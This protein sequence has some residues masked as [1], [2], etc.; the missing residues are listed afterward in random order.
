MKQ[1]LY[2]YAFVLLLL[3]AVVSVLSYGY[4]QGY[5]YIYFRHWQIQSNVWALLILLVVLSLIGQVAWLLFKRYFSRL[6]QRKQKVFNFEHLHPYEKMAVLWLL[7]ANQD[8]RQMV[9]GIFKQSSLLNEVI[10][11]FFLWKQG[12]AESA[13]K[14]LEHSPAMAFEL[15]E[16]Q[17][18]EIYLSAQQPNQ[19]LTH[20]EFLSQHELSPWLT[21][22][23]QG[24]KQRLIL[25]WGQFATQFPWLYLQSSQ[26]GQLNDADKTIWLQQI[27]LAF[28]QVSLDDLHH[29]Q[30][31]YD[32]FKTSKLQDATRE[33]KIL[34]LKILARL[35]EMG[36][37]HEELAEGL[38]NDLF[39]QEVF[40]LWFEKQL[41]KQSPDYEKVEQ[42]LNMWEQK[43]PNIPIFSFA[44]WFIYQETARF[45]EAEQLLELYP[46]NILMSYLRI[47]NQLKDND[48]LIRQLNFLFEGNSN[49]LKLNL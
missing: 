17:R 31:R 8:K 4:G 37:A 30:L 39:D 38:L 2:S 16:F 19:A 12:D 24:C 28:D 10:Q 46:D 13:L 25:L 9:E 41:L 15:A 18:I 34:W 7:D 20:L 40:Y 45:N 23:Q 33:N 11:A 29:L 44:R 27:L 22:I 47:K 1:I 42:Q 5:V 49:F 6:E 32:E 14:I 26:F 35:P 43:Y 36:Q 3:V 21:D 48:E